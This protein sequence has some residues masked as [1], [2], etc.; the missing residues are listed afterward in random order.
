MNKYEQTTE[1]KKAAIIKSAL[2]LFK[3]RGFTDVS[4]K[5]IATSAQVSQASIYNYFGSKEA[6]VA[7]CTKFIM[8][9]TF[10]QA[11]DLL[12]KE[13]FFIDK[14][15]LALSLC[16]ESLN[17]SISKYFT[18]KALCDKTLSSLIIN[19]INR[20]KAEIYREYI[21]LGKKEGAI[22]SNIPTE[23]YLNFIDTI[24]LL[25]SRTEYYKDN[26]NYTEYLH[27]LFLYGIIGK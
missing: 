13:M 16:S 4:M 27:K 3:E 7:E 25:G 6:V 9:D 5:E 23:I 1:K 14:L 21:E 17:K 19:Y 22:D 15:K 20:G 18:Q 2:S 10:K 24:N 11:F 26:E 12:E 8:E